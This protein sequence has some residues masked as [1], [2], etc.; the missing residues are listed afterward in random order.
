MSAHKNSTAVPSFSS[1]RA[2]LLLLIALTLFPWSCRE[3]SNSPFGEIFGPAELSGENAFLY[4]ARDSS[5]PSAVRFETVMQA[6]ALADGSLP[7]EQAW[8][9]GDDVVELLSSLVR[10]KRNIRPER[11]VRQHFGDIAQSPAPFA[12]V[13]LSGLA[14]EYVIPRVDAVNVKNQGSRG[15]CAAF[16][17][18]AHIEYAVLRQRPSL[19]TVDL[20][21][22]RFYY[23]AKPECQLDGCSLDWQGSSYTRGMTASVE[24]P[25]FDI[26]LESYCPYNAELAYNDLQVPQ[27]AACERGAVRVVRLDYV[28]QPDEIIRILERDGLPVPYASPLSENWEWNDGLITLAESDGWVPND[29]GHAY[30]IVGYRKLPHLP[31]EGGMCFI[32]KNSW[33]R[34]WGVNGYSCMT[35]AWMQRYRYVEDWSQPIAVELAIDDSLIGGADVQPLPDVFDPDTYD[36]E[37]VDDGDGDEILPEPPPVPE[38]AWRSADL[39]GPDAAFYPVELADEG[40]TL[41]LR[42][43]TRALTGYTGELALVRD[44]EALGYDGDRVGS[45]EG[46]R[47]ELCTGAWDLLCALRIDP[48]TNQLYIEFLY[49]ELR[50][51]ELDDSIRGEWRGFRDP[52]SGWRIEYYLPSSTMEALSTSALLLRVQDPSGA[53][54]QAQHFSLAGNQLMRLGQPVGTLFPPQLCS[55]QYEG[56]CRLLWGGDALHIIPTAGQPR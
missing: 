29:A 12:S 9:P 53:G 37:T 24:A 15:T 46:D 17:G 44:A 45:I 30:L 13:N 1:R 51:L 54:S 4:L 25:S 34:G 11:F 18:I 47:L 55:G 27:P 35:L 36:D 10:A 7:A 40:S 22:Q 39:L 31:Q 33:G 41:Y 19:A 52:L 38:R 16:T 20:S 6:L 23:N 50:N 42:G 8:A 49:P 14:D 5:R 28:S 2:Q 32:I 48:A 26:P 21:E 56:A 3:F 43:W